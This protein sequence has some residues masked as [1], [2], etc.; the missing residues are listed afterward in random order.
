MVGFA[1]QTRDVRVAADAGPATWEL[2]VLPFAE[3][4]K[5]IPIPPP[6][7]PVDRVQRAARTRETAGGP[8]DGAAGAPPAGGSFQRAGVTATSPGGTPAAAAAA[9]AAL[10]AGRPPAPGPVAPRGEDGGAQAASGD[11]FLVSGTVNSGAAPQ[12]SVGNVR[13]VTGIRLFNGQVTVSGNNSA[14]DARPYSLTGIPV[15]K[16]DTSRLNVSGIFSGP[17]RIPGLMRT[18]RNINVQYSR[19]A[20]TN[21]NTLSELM[22]TLLQRGGD[23]SQTFDGFGRPVQIVDPETGLPF[24]GNTIPTGRISPQ[25]FALLGYYPRPEP[26][27]TGTYNY[28]IPALSTSEQHRV[29]ASVSNIVNNTTNLVG[30]NVNYNRSV[31]DSTSL[32]GFDNSSHGSC[33]TVGLNWSRRFLPS[34][35][36]IR[37]RH[38]YTRQTNTTE[39]QFANTTNVSGDAGIT[40][41]NQDPVNWGPPSLSFSSGIAGLSDSQYSFNRTQSHAFGAETTR[42]RGRHNMSIGGNARYEMLDVVSQQNAR[43]AFTFNGGFSGHDFA[44]FLLGIPN[45][46]SIAFGNADKGFRAWTYDAYVNDDFR[47]SQNFTISMG[48]RWEFEAPVTERLGRLVNLDVAEDFSAAAP[49]IAEDGIGPITGRRYPRS[50]VGSN[51]WGIQPRFGLAW[52]PVPTSSVVLRAGYG[53][54]RNSS[55]YQTIARQMAQQPPLSRAF[56][57]MNTPET[58]LTLA[59]GFV[60]PISTTLNTV[61]YD[62]DFSVGTVHRW[63]ASTQRD[64]PGGLTAVATYLAGK[65]VNLPQAFIPNTYPAGTPN[66]CPI[67]PTGFVYTTSGG[68]SIQHAGQFE[69]RRRLRSG[70]TWSAGYT[71]SKATDDASLGGGDVAQNWLDLDAERGPSSSEQRHQFRVTAQYSTGQGVSGGALRTGIMAALVNGWTI[72]PNFTVGSGTPRTPVY[73]VTSVAGVTGTVRADLTGAPLDDAPEGYYVNPAAFAPPAPG[74]WG[75]AQRNSIRG[76]GTSSLNASITRQFPLR[77]RLSLNWQLSA[78]NVFNRVTYSNIN[79]VVGS[80]QF[81]LPTATSGMRRITTSLSTRF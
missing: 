76:P 18:T 28:Q 35:Q 42:S 15:R 33:L 74:T 81:G 22:P 59:N 13:R 78:T 50:L 68:S 2:S 53:I 55:V 25:A 40:G 60:A 57:S 56:N 24:A 63:Q 38:T 34:N 46:S 73:R 26:G 47:V 39:P 20:S 75:N 80:P 62:P 54:Y 30:G 14:L 52:R 66:P 77:N 16:P 1:T 48:V 70:L 27:A 64:L 21:A 41:N 11:A 17:I 44:D 45:T 32:F 37:M 7:P 4:T 69:L 61:A 43:G 29:S 8:R 5:G 10:A 58:P 72:S 3:I 23:F 71:L 65:G 79:T 36:Q 9:A 19:N 49:V 51:P 6:P 31:N 12:P 67:C